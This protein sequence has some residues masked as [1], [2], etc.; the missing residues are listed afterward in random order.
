MNAQE[1]GDELIRA[2]KK[3]ERDEARIR[4]TMALCKACGLMIT[5]KERQDRKGYCMPCESEINH[6]KK[7][8]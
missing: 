6:A 4:K 3:V 5:L 8:K 2:Y 1:L 7:K